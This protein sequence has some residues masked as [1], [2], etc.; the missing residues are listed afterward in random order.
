MEKQKVLIV[1][2]AK[3]IRDRLTSALSNLND[4]IEIHMATRLSEA[5]ACYENIHPHIIILDLSLPDGSGIRFLENVKKES[6]GTIVIIL[7]NFPFPQVK[8]KCKQ[9]GSD[10]FFSK[11]N[12]FDEVISVV[13]SITQ[14]NPATSDLH[15]EI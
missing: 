13:E 9:L 5:V 11:E 1:E 6:P 15:L 3:L 14:I 2:D 7:T 4:L 12:E 10:Y 8:K